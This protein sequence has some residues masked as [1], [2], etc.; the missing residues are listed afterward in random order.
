MAQISA[1]TLESMARIGYS[2]KPFMDYLD[3]QLTELQE[4]IMFQTDDVQVRILQGRAQEL[5][6]LRK[7]IKEAPDMARKA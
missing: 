2:E 6:R 7:L 1:N 3:V 5:Y 4:S